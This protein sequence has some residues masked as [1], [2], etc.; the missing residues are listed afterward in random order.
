MISK[1]LSFETS[2]TETHELFFVTP[3]SRTT[4]QRHIIGQFTTY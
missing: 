3:P 1:D 4:L 2:Q